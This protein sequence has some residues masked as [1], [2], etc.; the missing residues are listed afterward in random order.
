MEASLGCTTSDC[1]GGGVYVTAVV[2]RGAAS[3]ASLVVGDVIVSVDGR[4]VDTPDDFNALEKG[5]ELGKPID[6]TVVRGLDGR[7]EILKVEP[8]ANDA[9]EFTPQYVGSFIPPFPAVI[10]IA[11]L[12]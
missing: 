12:L 9:E 5:L 1:T 2:P 3:H 10:A 4:A 7:E 6:M 8:F 11:A